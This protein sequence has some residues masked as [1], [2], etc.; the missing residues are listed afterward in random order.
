MSSEKTSK[1]KVGLLKSLCHKDQIEILT[2]ALPVIILLFVFCYLPMGGLVLSFKDYKPVKGIF[3]SA[4]CGLDNFEFFFKSSDAARVIKN[5]LMYGVV[6]LILDTIAAIFIAVLLSAITSKMSLKVYQTT[7]ILPHF[8]S[9]IVVA[10]MAVCFLDYKSGLLNVFL[11]DKGF[12]PISWYSEPK[13]W[14]YIFMI[15]TVWKAAGYKSLVYYAAIIGIDT[16]LY[17]AA[18]IDGCSTWK[19]I[20]YIMIPLIKPTII[21]LFIMGLGNVFRADFGLFYQ[22]PQH[23]SA[24]IS[25]TDVLDTYIYRTLIST[26]D[27]GISSAVGM[28]QSVVGFILIVTVNA[29]VRRIEEDSAMF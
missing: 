20:R 25:T 27:V 4:W 21:I 26:G 9:M 28:L 10:F 12:D 1:K 16:E 23:S 11:R 6:F 2:M 13:Y 14:P 3:G 18:S 17:E 5:T 7:M 19:K 15:I 22:V 8:M 29:V 24:L